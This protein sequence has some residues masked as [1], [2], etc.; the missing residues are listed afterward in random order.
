MGDAECLSAERSSG[1]KELGVLLDSRLAMSQQC[2]LVAKAASGIL[3]CINM[4]MASR[5]REVILLLCS[6]LVRPHL[7]PC[8]EW[9]KKDRDLLGV[10]CVVTEMMGARSISHRRAD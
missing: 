10:Q 5:L 2:A 6:P 4:S 7:E 8:V 9:L 1:E 3:G